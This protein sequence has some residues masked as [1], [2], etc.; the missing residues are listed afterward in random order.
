[1]Y[2]LKNVL[3]VV[4]VMLFLLAT[5]PLS[6]QQ[7]YDTANNPKLPVKQPTNHFP[8]AKRTIRKHLKLVTKLPSELSE[9]S[10]FTVLHD[11]LIA[12][13]DG[14]NPAQ[15]F[16]I[17][18]S[19][20]YP[21]QL[22]AQNLEE[23]CDWEAIAQDSI[24]YY[25]GDFGNNP[26]SRK[27]LCIYKIE[28]KNILNQSVIRNEI[29]QMEFSYASQTNFSTAL[30]R[31]N[32]DCEAM[33]YYQGKLHLFSKNWIDKATIHYIVPTEEGNYSLTPA[34]RFDNCGLVTDAAINS[35]GEL[36]L[37]GYQKIC[38]WYYQCFIL[39][40][41]PSNNNYYFDNQPFKV[42]I[43]NS[44]RPGQVESIVWKDSHTLWIASEAFFNGRKPFK[45]KLYT[46]NLEKFCS[47]KPSSGLD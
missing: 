11:T 39:I 21:T 13:N 9:I 32:Y 35:K 25:I 26:G 1:M 33:I 44:F 18:T 40:F 19:P 20:P 10:G 17:S 15:L 23:N 16:C 42:K 37:L 45:A 14:G 22:F 8:Q 30:N 6:A 34:E 46:L 41:P 28:K 3:S 24:H 36:A 29:Q 7:K 38:G 31:N 5:M 27:N 12:I 2:P 43:G 4:A 47:D